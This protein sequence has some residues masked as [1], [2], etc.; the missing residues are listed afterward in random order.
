MTHQ[1]T[2][3]KTTT[4]EN[5]AQSAQTWWR[6]G[7]CWNVKKNCCWRNQKAMPKILTS[8]CGWLRLEKACHI[9]WC[10]ILQK[11]IKYSKICLDSFFTVTTVLE[12]WMLIQKARRVYIQNIRDKRNKNIILILPSVLNLQI[13]TQ[14]MW[15]S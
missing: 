10:E 15:Q 4:K 13:N 5:L 11:C 3:A 1:R 12:N 6:A 8:I 7:L 9:T 14:S 2:A